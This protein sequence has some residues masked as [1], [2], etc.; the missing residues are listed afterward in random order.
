[1]EM[2]ASLRSIRARWRKRGLSEPLDIR[3]GIHTDT[4][5]VGNFGSRDRLDY[6]TIGNGV[7]LASRLES[8]ARSNQI[9]ISEETYLLIREAIRCQ[10]L[11]KIEVKNMKHAVQTYEVDSEITAES[12]LRTVDTHLD[13]FSVYIDP[14][15][16]QN[17][18]EKREALERALKLIDRLD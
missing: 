6:T 17:L 8:N 9:L 14:E 13:G 15:D 18:T 2:K 12:V 16:T 1:M 10:K 11:D 4:C 5:T 3:I 7:N